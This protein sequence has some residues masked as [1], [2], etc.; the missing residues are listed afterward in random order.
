MMMTSRL[1]A[2]VRHGPCAHTRYGQLRPYLGLTTRA[3]RRRVGA[4]A[5]GG[6]ALL[7]SSAVCGGKVVPFLLADIGEGIAEVEVL[8]WHVAVG[9]AVGEFDPV[10]EVQSDKATVEITSRYEGTVVALHHETGDM[11][12]TGQALCDIELAGDDDDDGGGGGSGEAADPSPSAAAAAPAAAPAAVAAA[13]APA[14][15][16]AAVEARNASLGKV[17]TTPAVRRIARE[18]GIDLTLVQPHATCA[19]QLASAARCPRQRRRHGPGCLLGLS[20]LLSVFPLSK[21]RGVDGA[22]AVRQWQGGAHSKRGR[23]CVPRGRHRCGCSTGACSCRHPP[24]PA[25]AVT[26]A[27]RPPPLRSDGGGQRAAEGN[28]QDHDRRQRRPALH[29]LRRDRRQCARGA[30]RQAAG[31]PPPLRGLDE[32]LNDSQSYSPPG[33]GLGGHRLQSPAPLPPP[34]PDHT[35]CVCAWAQGVAEAAGL[36]RLTY[37]PFVI[38]AASMAL[39]RYPILNATVNDAD[40][41][42]RGAPAWH[43]GG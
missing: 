18:H 38:K 25:A 9:D 8:Q 32:Y 26:A 24:R 22:A 16:A 20:M 39:Q 6:V 23:A 4:G 3:A 29:L 1:A 17:L 13:A 7:H 40:G 34:P 21:L 5:H 2:A 33:V 14:S 36:R 27:G 15:S 12:P 11:A 37:M 30:A 28:D 10:C 41:A 19:R 31:A 42:V 43:E 35:T